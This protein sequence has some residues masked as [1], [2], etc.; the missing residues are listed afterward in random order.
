MTAICI[1]KYDAICNLGDNIDEIFET[2]LTD[3]NEH[4]ERDENFIK[5][6]PFFF[7]KVH[8]NL[9]KI[10]QKEYDTR[11]NRLLCTLAKRMNLKDFVEKYGPE[12]VAIIIATTNSGAEEFAENGNE[13]LSQIGNPAIFMQNLLN[14]KNYTASISTA[15]SSGIKIFSSAKR[16]IK[17]GFCKAAIVGGSDALAHLS[18]HGFNSLEILSNDKTQPFSK[19]RKGIN[20]GEGAALFT[21]EKNSCGIEILG[22]GET[23]DAYHASKPEPSGKQIVNAV[24]T[25][26][27]SANLTEKDIDYINL[28]GTGT[29]A[30]DETEATAMFKLFKNKTPCSSTKS[31]TGHCLGAA[32]AIETALCCKCLE[33]NTLLKHVYDDDF[34]TNLPKINLVHKTTKKELKHVMN[35]A[36]G[37]GGTNA[38]M[39]L[40][41]PVF[42]VEK[43]LPHEFPMILIDEVVEVNLDKHFIKTKV[44]IKDT[45]PFFDKKLNGISSVVGIE[46]MAQ[47]IGCYSFL[48]RG[49][50][51]ARMGFLLGTR[52]YNNAIEKFKNGKEYFIKSEEIYNDNEICAFGCQIFDDKQEEIACAT[53]NAYQPDNIEEMLKE[54]D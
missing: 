16:L 2:A 19:N 49:E 3:G 50:N 51:T 22:I 29:P 21:I 15:C 48:K 38:V 34:D 4:L 13:K 12:N 53:I 26:L 20:I 6:K 7:G 5:G 35:N 31:M 24:K 52:I 45:M 28:H 47:T 14:T 33:K 54:N 39:I 17:S 44:K 10:S 40:G 37:F 9:E 11:T 25:A 1:T 42:S 43:M 41:K 27:K 23:S 8:S 32:A 18:V 30:N 36:F 46:F